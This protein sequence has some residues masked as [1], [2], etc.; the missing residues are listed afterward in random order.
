LLAAGLAQGLTGRNRP[1]AGG[2]SPERAHANG[3]ARLMGV[4]A[5]AA[6]VTLVLAAGVA[7]LATTEERCWI[8][9]DTPGGPVFREIPP[10]STHSLGP[11]EFAGGCSSGEYTPGGIALEAGLL[12]V[13]IGIATLVARPGSDRAATA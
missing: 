3:R 5:A 13:A 10:T 2:V 1:I 9:T 7:A 12:A 4:L 8:R 11:D 6:L